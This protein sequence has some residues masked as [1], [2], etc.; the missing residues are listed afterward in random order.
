MVVAEITQAFT[1]FHL[2]KSL[3]LHI[4]RLEARW[5]VSA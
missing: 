4:G 5:R 3:K 2:M 1:L